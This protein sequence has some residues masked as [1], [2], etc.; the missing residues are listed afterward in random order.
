MKFFFLSAFLA[1]I[2]V[3]HAQSKSIFIGNGANI[4]GSTIDQSNRTTVKNYK[5]VNN[6]YYVD[7]YNRIDLYEIL[8]FYKKNFIAYQQANKSTTE[9]GAA[10]AEIISR[11][12]SLTACAVDKEWQQAYYHLNVSIIKLVFSLWQN[13]SAYDN[14]VFLRNEFGRIFAISNEIAT[15]TTSVE[16]LDKQ[17]FITR[18]LSADTNFLKKATRIYPFISGYA[19]Y[20]QNGKMGVVNTVGKIIFYPTFDEVWDYAE[21]LFLVRNGDEYYFLDSAG[22]KHLNLQAYKSLTAFKNGYAKVVYESGYYGFIDKNGVTLKVKSK[23]NG[24]SVTE[25]EFIEAS[26]FGYGMAFIK[27]IND[28]YDIKIINQS[29][30]L[31]KVFEGYFYSPFNS[32]GIAVIAEGYSTRYYLFDFTFNKISKAYN[33][34]TQLS[35]FGFIG[36][37][38]SF[39]EN[40]KP[41]DSILYLFDADGVL[42]LG[43]LNASGFTDYDSR[44]IIVKKR[45]ADKTRFAVINFHGVTITG[46]DYDKIEFIAD[47]TMVAYADGKERILRFDEEGFLKE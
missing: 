19:R 27:G 30:E 10:I 33:D 18:Q 42:K 21:G 40:N 12:D 32:S 9:A 45:V 14:S 26:E 44:N 22:K 13:S 5:T 36:F 43:G 46:F 39:N 41:E 8:F 38:S 16:V 17:P 2:L 4:Y 47:K 23:F 11:I 34:I 7:T 20:K 6:I 1:L 29:G 24:K 15:N 37:N 3:S 25:S 31:L 28:V 35:D